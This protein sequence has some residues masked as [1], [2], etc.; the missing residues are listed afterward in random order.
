MDVLEAIRTRRTV[1]EFLPDRVPRELIEQVLEAAIWAPNHRLTEPW[2]FVVLQRAALAR[3]GELR[4]QM[5]VDYL[6]GKGAKQSVIQQQ[7]DDAYRKTVGAP[8]TIAVTVAQ[9]AD[10]AVREEDY[11]ATMA[12]VQNLMLAAHALGLASYLSTNHLIGYPP[13]RALIGVPD[14]RRIFGLVQLGYPARQRES[15]RTPARAHTAWLD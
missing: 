4:R 6:T 3:L 5:T 1:K 9:H 11:A 10:P 7:G 2:G 15:K 12:A 14:D 8:V 13:A